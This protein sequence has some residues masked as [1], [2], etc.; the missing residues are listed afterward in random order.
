MISAT[1]SDGANHSG[2]KRSKSTHFYE[3]YR[4]KMGP[5][6][7]EVFIKFCY[8]NDLIFPACIKNDFL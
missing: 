4:D 6:A 2:E 1:F 5:N 3:S 8:F 7:H